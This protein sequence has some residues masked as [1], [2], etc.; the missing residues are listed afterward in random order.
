MLKNNNDQPPM[1]QKVFHKIR[2][3]IPNSSLKTSIALLTKLG[4]D[5]TRKENLDQV[6]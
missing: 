5:I 2:R 1:F 4:K 3:E 6:P